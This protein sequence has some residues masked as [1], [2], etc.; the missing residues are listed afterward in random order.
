MISDIVYCL[1]FLFKKE[2]KYWRIDTFI[3]VNSCSLCPPPNSFVNSHYREFCILRRLKN[4]NNGKSL[5]PQARTEARSKK[6]KEWRK[7]E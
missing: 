3:T 5:R 1:L 2:K 4:G 7:S 6:A